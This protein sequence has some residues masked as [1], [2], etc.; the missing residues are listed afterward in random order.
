MTDPRPILVDTAM[1][2]RH[3]RVAI[4]T[5]Y[6]WA[7]EDK[8]TRHGTPRRQKWD[9]EEAQCSYEKRRQ[10]LDKPTTSSETPVI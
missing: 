9:L 1:V 8:W 7:S 10:E 6:R 5:V 4:G 2:A 3:Y